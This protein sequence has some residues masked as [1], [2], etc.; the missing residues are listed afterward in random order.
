[1][2]PVYFSI[3][4]V[5]FMAVMLIGG[6]AYFRQEERAKQQSRQM[7]ELRAVNG[8]DYPELLREPPLSCPAEQGPTVLVFEFSTTRRENC[9][10]R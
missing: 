7:A 5:L 6:M 4:F 2:P 1:M 9:S 8:L 3:Y 10:G